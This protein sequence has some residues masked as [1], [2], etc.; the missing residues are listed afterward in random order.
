LVRRVQFAVGQV[1][2]GEAGAETPVA[3]EKPMEEEPVVI[4]RTFPTE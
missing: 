1:V 2:Q 3:W 4:V